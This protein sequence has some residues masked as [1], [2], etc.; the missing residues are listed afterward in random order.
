MKTHAG[1]KL[2]RPTG[3]RNAMLKEMASSLFKHEQIRTTF[4][5]AK[6][7]SRF[8]D[9]VITVAKPKNL[10]SF[11]RLCAIIN[12]KDVRRK[13]VDVLV[14][15]YSTR[16]GGYTRVFRTINRAGDNA[17]MALVKLVI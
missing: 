6:E 17:E 12:H 11:K 5:K 1:R 14:P 10:T 4:A 2:N 16:K 15:R 7:V 3:P 13:V 8:A 9:H